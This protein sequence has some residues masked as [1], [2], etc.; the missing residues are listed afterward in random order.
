MTDAPRKAR[1][2]IVDDSVV[3]RRILSVMLEG[4]SRIEVAATASSGKLAMNWIATVHPDVVTLDVEMPEWD[5]L[6][7]LREIRTVYPT[8]PVIMCSSLTTHGATT[9][10]EAL[11]LGASDCIAKPTSLGADDGQQAFRR[12][13]AEK[14]LGLCPQG[15]LGGAKRVEPAPAVAPRRSALLGPVDVLA[16][17]CSTGGPQA[18]TALFGQ[19]PAPVGVPTVVVQHMPPIFTRMLA[20]RLND[21]TRHAVHEGAEGVAI[22]PGA[23][24]IAPGD[25]H[26][27]TRRSGASVHLAL[28]TGA[29]VNSCR[30]SVDVLF[31]SVAEAYGGRVL[32]V[33]LTGMGADGVVGCRAIRDAGGQVIVQD[34]A[35]SVVW[36]MPG[37]VAEAGLAE[38]ILP[39]DELPAEIARRLGRR[40]APAG[41]SRSDALLASP[42][43]GRYG[44]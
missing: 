7:T 30:P 41:T 28:H 44:A 38:A 27:V 10:I 2:L 1:V 25:F 35:S 34:E 37:R 42:I 39:L 19:L 9:A 22:A 32:A 17:G 4:D 5:G 11:S 18:L 33:V 16:I 13:L 14:I 29:P 8:L 24:W 20:A 3:M 12:E 36:G 43:G 6:R 15:S 31:E 40:G 26:M 23:A 21:S